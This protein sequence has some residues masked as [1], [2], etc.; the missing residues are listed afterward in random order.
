[1]A[2]IVG[3]LVLLGFLLLVTGCGETS[4]TVPVK[5]TIQFEGQPL[6]KATVTFLAQQSGGRDAHGFTDDRGVF[7]LSTFGTNDGALPGKYK[8][9]VYVPQEF[10]TSIPAA[11]AEE[12]QKAMTEGRIKPKSPAVV[13]PPLYSHPEQTTLTQEVPPAGEVILN[14]KKEP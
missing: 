12:A 10:D 7:Q 5:G 2:R 9:T 14:L 4:G 13:I 3:S 8:V 11:T 6:A 1:M